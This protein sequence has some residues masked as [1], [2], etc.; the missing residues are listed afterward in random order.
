MSTRSAPLLLAILCRPL[1]AEVRDLKAF[2]QER[3]AVCHGVDGT[4][5]G[6]NG[7]RLG[8]GNLTGIRQETKEQEADLV[9]SLLRGK[10]AMPGFGRQLSEPEALRLLA[11][12]A[13]LPR[14]AEKGKVVAPPE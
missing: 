2:Y 10:G 13:K 3:C 14:K 5:R 12:L 8:G 4:G 9:A 6:P 7:G 11:S 1:S